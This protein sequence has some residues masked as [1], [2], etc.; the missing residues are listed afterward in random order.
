MNMSFF[1]CLA[2]IQSLP[3][4]TSNCIWEISLF[5]CGTVRKNGGGLQSLL[6]SL[7]HSLPFVTEKSTGH[8][9]LLTHWTLY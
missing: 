6:H 2:S 8:H 7:T 5:I 3:N 4:I 9:L 1:C